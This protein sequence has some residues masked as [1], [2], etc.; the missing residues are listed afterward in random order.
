[1][2]AVWGFLIMCLQ[3]AFK[4]FIAMICV[5]LLTIVFLLLIR[6]LEMLFEMSEDG[7]NFIM[8]WIKK[9]CQR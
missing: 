7:K 9:K 8:H 4:A 6:F 2:E 5:F 3:A 1:M